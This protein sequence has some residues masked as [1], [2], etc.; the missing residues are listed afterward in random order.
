[1]SL[2]N[3]GPWDHAIKHYQRPHVRVFEFPLEEE[4][5]NATIDAIEKCI[6]Q[7]INEEEV[8]SIEQCRMFVDHT[9]LYIEVVYRC[10]KKTNQ[11]KQLQFILFSHEKL[12][13][14]ISQANDFLCEHVSYDTHV[15]G[16][17]VPLKGKY[18]YGM[19]ILYND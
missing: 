14:C 8:S 15:M 1:M 9:T 3:P 17:F 19:F 2:Y 4:V 10:T 13:K 6:D 7:L 5:S 18:L 16:C 11:E 12:N